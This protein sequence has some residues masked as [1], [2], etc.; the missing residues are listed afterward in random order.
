MIEG[1][2]T[3]RTAIVSRLGG[4]QNDIGSFEGSYWSS[5]VLVNFKASLFMSL[6]SSL[7]QSDLYLGIN[8]ESTRFYYFSS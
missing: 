7:D 5:V 1:F 8:M 4:T 3:I 2:E 6:I